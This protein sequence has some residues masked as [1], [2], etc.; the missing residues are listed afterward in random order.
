MPTRSNKDIFVRGFAKALEEKWQV[1]VQL[2]ARDSDEDV[3]IFAQKLVLASRS[4]VLK[5]ILN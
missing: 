5:K 1:D 3:S 2:K 4:E